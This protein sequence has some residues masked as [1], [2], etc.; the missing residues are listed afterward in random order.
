MNGPDK[1]RTGILTFYASLVANKKLPY[2]KQ[3]K[4]VKK[5]LNS[6]PG[7]LNMPG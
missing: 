1:R 4:Q 2:S 6:V 5:A 7:T 3:L